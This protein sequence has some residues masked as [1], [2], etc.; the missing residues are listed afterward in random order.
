ML[1]RQE[2]S[3]QG[4]SFGTMETN[5]RGKVH[6]CNPNHRFGLHSISWTQKLDCIQFIERT[7]WI[8]AAAAAATAVAA[9]RPTVRSRSRSRRNRSCSRTGSRRPSDR[10]QPQPE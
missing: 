1:D 2:E 4:V 3:A 8:D 7:N 6:E 9:V 5:L 10:P